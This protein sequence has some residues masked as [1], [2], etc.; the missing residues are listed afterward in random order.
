[1]VISNPCI[2][3]WLLYHKLADL[4]ELGIETAKDAKQALDKVGKY[5]WVKYLPLMPIAIENAAN[6]DKHPES[7]MP[8]LLETKVYLLGRALYERMGKVR[9]E[10]FVIALQKMEKE[11]LE[12]KKRKKKR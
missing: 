1:M 10:E 2:E 12:R 6:A 4:S 8:E 7:Y 3:I 5:Y 11:M 9:F